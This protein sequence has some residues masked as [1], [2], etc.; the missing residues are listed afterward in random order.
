ML[1]E[2]IETRP[3][4][5]GGAEIILKTTDRRAVQELQDKYVDGK[6]YVAE[7]KR[8]RRKRSLDA[9]AYMWVLC[10]K[11]ADAIRSTKEAVYREA[12]EQVGVFADMA[13]KD[14]DVDDICRAWVHKGIGWITEYV[15]NTAKPGGEII[16][17]YKGSSEYDTKQMSR[18]I[19]YLVGEAKELGIE[20]M[21]PDELERMMQ[22]WGAG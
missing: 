4:W 16:R 11:I 15:G 7:I 13:V 22:Q 14:R 8:Y 20:T 19:D 18:L 6:K 5:D 21:P 12:V 3:T 1:I 17:F 2:K 9:N 10:D